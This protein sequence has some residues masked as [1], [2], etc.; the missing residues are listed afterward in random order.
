MK[1][2]DLEEVSKPVPQLVYLLVLS[3]MLSLAAPT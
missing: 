1:I 2:L 3:M